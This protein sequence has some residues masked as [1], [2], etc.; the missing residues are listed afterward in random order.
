MEKP[1]STRRTINGILTDINR[2]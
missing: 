2:Y 1:I